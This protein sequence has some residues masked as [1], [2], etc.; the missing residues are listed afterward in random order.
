[1]R[2]SNYRSQTAGRTNSTARTRGLTTPR[3][4]RDDEQQRYEKADEEDVVLPPFALDL[5]LVAVRHGGSQRKH[6]AVL[7]DRTS[8]ERSRVGRSH[9]GRLADGAGQL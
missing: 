1:M 8:G 3:P 4:Q 5:L 9:R 6:K 7:P 2:A